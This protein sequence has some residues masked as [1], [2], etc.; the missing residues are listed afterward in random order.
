M[1]LN[2]L[3][4][5]QELLARR[6]VLAALVAAMRE[7][8]QGRSPT[9]LDL[10]K[11]QLRRQVQQWQKQ[12]RELEREVALCHRLKEPEPS[13]KTPETATMI[14]HQ[15]QT[16]HESHG[17]P[18]RSLCAAATV[19]YPTFMRWKG[20]LGRGEPVLYKPGPKPIGAAD[21][22]G[23]QAQ[24]RRLEHGRHRSQGTTALYET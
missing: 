11:E 17:D 16:L 4:D 22:S 18:Y 3:P 8:P 24:L 20:R 23:L 19:T 12:V 10:Q 5:P 13:K 14:V 7:R 1:Q 21:L 2:Q 9:P 6:R 15:L